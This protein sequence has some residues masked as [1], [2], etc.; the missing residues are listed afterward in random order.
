MENGERGDN[1]VRTVETPRNIPTAQ[2]N[3]AVRREIAQHDGIKRLTLTY[4]QVGEVEE[5]IPALI[6]NIMGVVLI[7]REILLGRMPV[8]IL[9]LIISVST[10]CPVA[11]HN[12]LLNVH[13]APN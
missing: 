12:P 11:T 7:P 5:R 3:Q 10:A 1:Y 2:A 6:T 8:L 4:L 9:V 13:S